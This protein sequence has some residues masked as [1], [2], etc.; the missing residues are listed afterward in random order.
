MVKNLSAM[1]KTRVQSLGQ[2]H[3]LEKGMAAHSSGILSP[4]ESHGQ[5]NLMGYSPW[6]GKELDMNE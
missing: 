2:E 4:G 5:R 3:R 1:Q 6:D